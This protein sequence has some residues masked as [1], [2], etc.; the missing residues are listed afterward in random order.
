MKQSRPRGAI[1]H[2][3][4]GVNFGNETWRCFC[5]V[6][7]LEPIMSS[8]D[9]GRNNSV[10]ELSASGLKKER[11]KKRIYRAPQRRASSLRRLHR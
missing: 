3:D 9:N 11:A 4:Q 10:V 6:H 2:S 5:R 1:I 7:H 8:I